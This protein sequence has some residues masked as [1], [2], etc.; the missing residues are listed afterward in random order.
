MIR[1]GK[2]R[3]NFT[4]LPNAMLEDRSMSIDT[5]GMMAYLLSRPDDWEVRHDALC[6]TL[7]VTSERLRRMIREGLEAGYITRDEAQPRDTLNR[8]TSY[9]YVVEDAPQNK[10]PVTGFPSTETRQRKLGCG[11]DN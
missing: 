11:T 8:F 7:S 5:R 6:R 9:D 10:V 3:K 4:V 2:H 1:R